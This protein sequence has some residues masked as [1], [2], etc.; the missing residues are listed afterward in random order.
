M[1]ST[2]W[3]QF[4]YTSTRGAQDQGINLTGWGSGTVAES[5]EVAYEGVNSIRISTRNF[6]QGG[7]IQFRNAVNVGDKF[8]DKAQL[9]LF[10]IN[11]PGAG[12]TLGGGG[13]A[14]GRGG[15]MA[16]G[17]GGALAGGSAAGDEG[18]GSPGRGGAAGAA[19]GQEKPVTRLRVVV[20]TSD[21]KRS[22]GFLDVTTSVKDQRGWFKAGLPLQ[23]ISGLDKTNKQITGIAISADATTTMYVG[24]VEVTTDTSPIFVE[25]TIKEYNVGSGQEASFSAIGFAGATPVRFVWDFNAADGIQE[26]AEGSTVRRRF[27]APGTYTV[28][29]TG[30]DVFGLKKPFSATIRVTV[31]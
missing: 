23:G 30:V 22:E 12:T 4:L 19:A 27:R 9:L 17:G 31:N 3:G 8:S 20:T 6:F 26:E 16:G 21:G 25:P 13:N 15:A 24:A 10:T 14:P 28:T 1:T 7:L 18:F 11:I 5:D 29:V 2:A